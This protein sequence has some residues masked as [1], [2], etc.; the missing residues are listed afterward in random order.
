MEIRNNQGELIGEINSVFTENGDRVIT[1]TLYD[2]RG[3]PAASRLTAKR[4]TLRWGTGSC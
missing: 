1:N 3:N 4:F 2:Y